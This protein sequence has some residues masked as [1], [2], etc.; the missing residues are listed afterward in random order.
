M[1]NGNNQEAQ[2][3]APYLPFKT[4]LSAIEALEQV[5][6]KKIDRT[7]WRSQSGLTQG[8]IM[9]AFRFF[10]LIDEKDQPTV[11]LQR[12]VENKAE[13]KS[14]IAKMVEKAYPTIL[15]RDLTKLTPKLLEDEMGNYGVTGTTK[16]KAVSFFLQAAKFA[17]LPLSPFLQTQVRNVGPRKRRM[18]REEDEA[19]TSSADSLTG[20]VPGS[21]RSVTL[22]SGGSLTLRVSADL[23]SLAGDDRKF[24]FDLIDKLEEYEKETASE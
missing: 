5:V 19:D 12:L 20:L 16:Q 9:S 18:R 15:A 6:P 2:R 17:E 22:K 10:A 14:I 21:S 1:D 13:R 23:L 7:L 4:F 3:I 8:L 24:V 11:A